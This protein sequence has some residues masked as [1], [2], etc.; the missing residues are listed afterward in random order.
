MSNDLSRRS[1]SRNMS[2]PNMVRALRRI[3][4][5]MR[6]IID[7]APHTWGPEASRRLEEKAKDSVQ[8]TMASISMLWDHTWSET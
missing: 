4:A 2:R 5:E 7:A 1:S 3:E 6:A 8:I